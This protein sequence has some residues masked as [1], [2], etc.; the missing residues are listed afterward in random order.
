MRRFSLI[1]CVFLWGLNPVSAQEWEVLGFYKTYYNWYRP[2]LFNHRELVVRQLGLTQGAHFSLAQYVSM[3]TGWQGW[4]GQVDVLAS[5]VRQDKD[6]EADLQV[7]QLYLQKDMGENWVLIAGRSLQRWGTGYAFNPTDVVAPDKELSDLDNS[8]KRIGGNDMVKLEYFGASYSLAFCYLASIQTGAKLKLQNSRAA[9]RFYKNLGS[10]DLSLVSLISSQENPVW[11][12][13]FAAVIGQRLEVHG[14]FSMQQGSY[15]KYHRI[16]VD[17]EFFFPE[18]P[19]LSFKSNDKR[20]YFQLLWGWQFTFPGN[21]F[22]ASEYF[23]QGQG[24]SKQEWR[25]V[26]DYMAILPAYLDTQAHD[27]AVGN[28]LWSLNVYRPG[29]A[30]R[31]YWMN[32]VQIPASG[33]GDFQLLITQMLNLSDLSFVMIPQVSL[34]QGN[35]FTFYVRSY[36]FQGDKTSE[37]GAFFQSA[38]IEAGLRFRL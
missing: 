31:H 32:H 37:Y 38:T 15:R 4:Q 5:A 9:F 6:W 22:W 7:Q 35:H 24:Y 18:E 27:I 12:L 33:M 36:I 34:S 23:H 14:E 21:I 28:L 11:G 1:L 26:I 3:V 8:E 16:L 30:M 17:K 25:R 29:G 10:L 19:F 2:S 13:N 20:L